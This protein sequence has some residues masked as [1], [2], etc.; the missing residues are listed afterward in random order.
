MMAQRRIPRIDWQGVPSKYWGKVSAVCRSASDCEELVK[1]YGDALF[2]PIQPILLLIPGHPTL[3]VGLGYASA[4]ELKDDAVNLW[5][6]YSERLAKTGSIV[7]FSELRER[8]Q[9]MRREDVAARTAEAFWDRIQA[10][11]ASPVTDPAR[12]PRYPRVNGKTVFP[13]AKIEVTP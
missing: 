7:N 6:K 8:N 2:C 3:L 4:A 11:K 5:G 10:H 12:Q 13:V 9:L 1:W